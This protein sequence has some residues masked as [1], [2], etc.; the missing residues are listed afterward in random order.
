MRK[1]HRRKIDRVGRAELPDQSYIIDV[2]LFADS[3]LKGEI[4]QLDQ[5]PIC[6][7]FEGKPLTYSDF[8]FVAEP[9]GKKV[10]QRDGKTGLWKD[11]RKITSYTQLYSSD[12]TCEK[13]VEENK[14]ATCELQNEGR[15]PSTFFANTDDPQMAT[16]NSV[17]LLQEE[18]ESN[19]SSNGIDWGNCLY[20]DEDDGGCHSSSLLGRSDRKMLDQ[21]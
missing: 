1:L 11:D 7:A 20:C 16:F 21:V 18:L 19:L 3:L 12:L 4:S 13:E 2:N 15:L 10:K 5:P 14:V 8:S 6:R 9:S 17:G